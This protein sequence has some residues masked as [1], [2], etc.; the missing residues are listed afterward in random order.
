MITKRDNKGRL[1]GTPFEERLTA[2]L[3]R[4]KIVNGCWL[5]QGAKTGRGQYAL[6][7][8]GG[9][10][11]VRVSRVMLERSGHQR[12]SEKHLACHTCD[13]PACVN[14]AHLF[15]GTFSENA[16]D[17]KRKGRGNIPS[18]EHLQKIKTAITAKWANPEFK[19]QR[20]ALL[21][22]HNQTEAFRIA[23]KAGIRASSRP[24]GRRKVDI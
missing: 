19:A 15:W 18:G 14:P 2:Q 17:A 8:N 4:V 20:L 6:I 16:L 21:A 7:R 10:K 11:P 22:K 3:D 9:N 5:W 12:P 13:E 1:V 24:H 23:V